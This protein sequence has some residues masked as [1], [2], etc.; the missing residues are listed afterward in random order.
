MPWFPL[1]FLY[2]PIF[3]IGMKLILDILGTSFFIYIFA[4]LDY[5]LFV[6]SIWFSWH[7]ILALIW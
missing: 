4:L 5:L 6:E 7:H 3:S 2:L 1:Q